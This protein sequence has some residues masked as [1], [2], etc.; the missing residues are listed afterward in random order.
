MELFDS[1]LRSLLAHSAHSQ[2]TATIICQIALALKYLHRDAGVVHLDVSARNVLWQALANRAV[3][4][5]YSLATIFPAQKKLRGTTCC[6]PNYRPPELLSIEGANVPMALVQPAI[7][8][9]SFGCVLW[10]IKASEGLP[11]AH[12]MQG[13][14]AV[15]I[16][17]D[18]NAYK[19][20]N[21]SGVWAR[22]LS[23]AGEWEQALRSLLSIRRHERE[24]AK[25]WVVVQSAK[26]RAAQAH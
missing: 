8:L 18:M 6:A 16:K 1:D 24:L 19:R 13:A 10:E 5:D 22:R 11:Y 12:M 3:L 9:W 17:S 21:T 26:E 7:D 25:T 4:A 2:S 15:T 20:D 14:D 23:Q